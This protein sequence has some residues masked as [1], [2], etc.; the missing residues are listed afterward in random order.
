MTRREYLEKTG[1]VSATRPVSR[2]RGIAVKLSFW[3]LLGATLIF[4]LVFGYSYILSRRLLVENIRQYAG[5]LASS[6]AGKIDK[7]L[8]A[9]EK[10][11]ESLSLYIIEP[12]TSGDPKRLLSLMKGVLESN[13]EIYGSAIAFEPYTRDPKARLYSPYWYKKG[14]A[15]ESLFIQYDYFTWDW[16]KTPKES[17]RPEWTEPYF[18]EGAGNIVMSTYS[19]PFFRGDGGEKKFAGIVT[20]DISLAW[21]QKIVSDIKIGKTGYAF[22]ISK[23]GTY[24]TH[25]RSSLI[26]NK[27]IFGVAEERKDPLIA[28]IGKEMTAGGTGFVE[29]KSM[30]TEQPSWLAY[31]S[32]SSTGWSLGLMFPR[33]ELMAD[34]SEH[35][36]RTLLLSGLGFL[37]LF[38]LIAWIARGI[39]RPLRLLT[40]SAATM[41]G[42]DLEMA[43]PKIRGR[44][45]VGRLAD[46]FASMQTSLKTYIKELTETAA[47]KERIESELRVAHDIQMG[48]LPRIFPPFP[49]R[50][51]LDIY[52]TLLPAREVGGDLYDFFFMDDDHLC[53]SVGDVSGKGVPASLFMAVTKILIK[54]KAVQGLAPET[55]LSRVNEDLALENPSELFVTLFL[56]ILNV[57]TGEL[58]Y[59][60]GGHPSPYI[61]GADGKIYPLASTGGLA[62][63]IMNDFVYTSHSARINKG[64]DIFVFSDG[65]TE[66]ADTRYDLFEEKRLEEALARLKGQPAKALISGVL[67]KIHDFTGS[68]P[69]ADDITML[70]VSYFGSDGTPPAKG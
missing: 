47:A 70:M 36:R 12:A 3:I 34:V 5:Q 29:T 53:F 57:R 38:C 58:V 63:G 48:I 2:G 54:A 68:A 62:L 42:G 64:D 14:D 4:S 15:I 67:E 6:T 9:T 39:T 28:E 44:D 21:L 37:F 10:I 52:A 22:L 24:V 50:T 17:G 11:P 46:S 35:Y 49:D 27:T 51:D 55:I 18:D 41:A 33:D 23:K 65:V 13:P 16:Y 45:E 25:P 32:L 69:Q 56:G 43:V 7:I 20:I 1:N 30:I 59:S 31:T 19:V 60:N 61:I 26:M 66:A 40:D 8:A